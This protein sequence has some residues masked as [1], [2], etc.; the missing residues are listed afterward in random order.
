MMFGKITEEKI[1]LMISSEVTELKLEIEKLKTHIN[2]LRGLINRRD[3][4]KLNKDQEEEI[5]ENPK[6]DKNK[7]NVLIPI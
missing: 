7:K 6:K 1:K 5:E 2:S 3:Q 4:F